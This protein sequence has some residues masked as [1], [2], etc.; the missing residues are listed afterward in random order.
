MSDPFLSH[1]ELVDLTGFK[2]PHCQA[3]WLTRNRWRFVL[4]R[5]NEPK[6][7]RR[8]FTD[9]MGCGDGGGGGG[10]ASISHVHPINQAAAGEQP[11]FAALDRR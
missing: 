10:G 2:A 11:N 9:R 7:A 5:H 4:N 8:H 3:R 6:V 1:A